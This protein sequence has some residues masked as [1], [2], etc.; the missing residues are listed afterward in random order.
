MKAIIQQKADAVKT[1]VEDLQN[2]KAVI[3]FEY[4]G[5]NA[6]DITLMRRNLHFANAKMYVAKNNI[7]NR[8][9]KE[10]N[11]TQ[12]S[13]LSGPNALIVA[14]GDEIIPFKEL[15]EMMKTYKQIVYKQGMINNQ[16]VSANQVAELATIPG[17]E[18]LFSMLLSCLQA[19]IRG[20]AC[21]VKAIGDSK[22][23]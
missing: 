22:Q 3:A 15:N 14:H 18:G 13:E 1:L 20:F 8:A 5:A 23:Q 2:A 21:A 6:K 10:A 17:R 11:L 19:P 16:M 7:F 9:L 12:F 4:H